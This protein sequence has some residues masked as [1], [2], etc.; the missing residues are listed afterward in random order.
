MK[1]L[2]DRTRPMGFVKPRRKM[3]LLFVCLLS[4]VQLHLPLHKALL[5]NF[6]LIFQLILDQI[7][8]HFLVL[9]QVVEVSFMTNF[10]HRCFL[11]P[12]SF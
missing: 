2:S 11:P 6:G 10:G 3:V 9:I 1:C 8:G 4:V 12:L 5:Q 7:G